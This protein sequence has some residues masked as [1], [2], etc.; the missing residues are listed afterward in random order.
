MA[1]EG[2]VCAVGDVNGDGLDD[3]IAFSQNRWSD[4]RA[5]NVILLANSTE[6][7]GGGKRM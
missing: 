4:E 3:I 5:N 1:S 2:E 6:L 7:D